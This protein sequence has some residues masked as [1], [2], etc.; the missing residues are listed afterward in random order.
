METIVDEPADVYVLS[1][2]YIMFRMTRH[3]EFRTEEDVDRM[4]VC[5][6]VA[7]TKDAAN[8]CLSEYIGVE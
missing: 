7:T 4:C 2:D 3:F 6:C 8:N 1:N 5:L